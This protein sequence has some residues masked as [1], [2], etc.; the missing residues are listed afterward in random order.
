MVDFNAAARTQGQIDALEKAVE[1]LNNG[2]RIPNMRVATAAGVAPG[3]DITPDTSGVVLPPE[4]L[5]A[6]AD[7]MQTQAN[8]MKPDLVEILQRK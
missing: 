2:G 8:A 6:I 7:A 1:I 3:E 4:I 5:T